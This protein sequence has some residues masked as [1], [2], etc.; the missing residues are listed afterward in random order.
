MR[1]AKY[2]STIAV[3]LGLSSF[4][5]LAFSAPA[6]KVEAH[7]GV[8]Q[9][10]VTAARPMKYLPGHSF[11]VV[12]NGTTTFLRFEPPLAPKDGN[13]YAAMLEAVEA[14][15]PVGDR[16]DYIGP[17]LFLKQLPD[18]INAIALDAGKYLY[19]ALPARMSDE[20]RR[21]GSMSIWR[22]SK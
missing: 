1:P 9:L 8:P 18:G 3:L 19:L 4:S 7:P 12:S 21:V 6:N 10:T 13:I 2:L 15:Y 17:K 14:R 16:G 5:P 11:E 22:E 20:D